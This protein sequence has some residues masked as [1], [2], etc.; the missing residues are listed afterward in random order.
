MF[1]GQIL[2]YR[3]NS[4]H[5]ATGEFDRNLFQLKDVS[6][7]KKEMFQERILESLD[8]IIP[9][10]GYVLVKWCG[11]L[12]LCE[13]D[14]NNPDVPYVRNELQWHPLQFAFSQ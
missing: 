4:L 14:T 9:G 1:I 6:E 5:N 7:Q 2:I 11:R 10:T 3:F 13:K 12:F 8:E